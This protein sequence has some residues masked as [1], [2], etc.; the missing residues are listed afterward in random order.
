[1]NLM[2]TTSIWIAL[3]T[4]KAWC[5]PQLD[6]V[7]KRSSLDLTT[8]DPDL[9]LNPDSPGSESGSYDYLDPSFAVSASGFIS[10]NKLNPYLC[11]TY[12]RC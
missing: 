9:G 10:H 7:E 6:Y 8:L 5:L 2:L 3:V 12:R 4:I 1:M 11:C